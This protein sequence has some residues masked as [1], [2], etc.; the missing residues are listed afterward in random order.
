MTIYAMKLL[1]GRVAAQLRCRSADLARLSRN[2]FA[3][4]GCDTSRV[5][6]FW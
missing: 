4:K 2:L 6:F 1:S 5:F 3:G